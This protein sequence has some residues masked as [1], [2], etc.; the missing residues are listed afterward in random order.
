MKFWPLGKAAALAPGSV[1][2]NS[3]AAAPDLQRHAEPAK[4]L[5]T[6]KRSRS[7]NDENGE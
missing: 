5:T 1:H 7:N 6:N 3:F 4:R 2:T